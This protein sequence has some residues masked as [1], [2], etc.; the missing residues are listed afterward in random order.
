MFCICVFEA[1]ESTMVANAMLG[2][3]STLRPAQMLSDAA[4]PVP[5]S[6]GAVA[7]SNKGRRG[8]ISCTA[9]KRDE[10]VRML[11]SVSSRLPHIYPIR[12]SYRLL[13]SL[14]RKKFAC[15]LNVKIYHTSRVHLPALAGAHV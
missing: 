7:R 15:I 3:Q 6:S 14:N 5:F 2:A 9:A 12:C 1:L 13:W 4:R 11:S 8:Q 10:N